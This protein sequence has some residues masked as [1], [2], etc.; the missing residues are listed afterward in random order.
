MHYDYKCPDCG[1]EFDDFQTVE[2]R[3]HSICPKC[4]ALADLLFR[5]IK[6]TTALHAFVPYVDTNLAEDGNPVLVES[7]SQKRRLMKKQGLEWVPSV[8]WI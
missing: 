2:N 4:G 5:P 7:R 8:R 6:M 1:I 3:R